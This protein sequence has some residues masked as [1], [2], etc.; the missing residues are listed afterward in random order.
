MS[1]HRK[2][3]VTCNWIFVSFF[4]FLNKANSHKSAKLIVKGSK[5]TNLCIYF[6]QQPYIVSKSEVETRLL[7]SSTNRGVL[8]NADTCRQG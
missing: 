3:F 1:Q 7:V 8:S 2:Y 5:H 4:R 6:S